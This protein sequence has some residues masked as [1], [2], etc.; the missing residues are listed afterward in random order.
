MKDYKILSHI[1]KEQ[2]VSRFIELDNH[3]Y[4]WKDKV[5]QQLI[6]EFN[7]CSV[8]WEE[9]LEDYLDNYKHHCIGK[10]INNTNRA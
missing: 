6:E 5:Y 2:Y 9:L 1:P 10:K 8:T 4:V 7:I 3:G